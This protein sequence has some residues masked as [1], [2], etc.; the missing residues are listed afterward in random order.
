MSSVAI[1]P[2]RSLSKG[3]KDKNLQTVGGI[4]LVG[5]CIKTAKEANVDR[6]VVSTDGIKLAEEARCWN[7]EIVK[8]P[9][10]LA[11]DESSS[12]AALVHVLETVPELQKYRVLCFLQATSTFCSSESV[13][14]CISAV[15]DGYDCAFTVVPTHCTLWKNGENGPV[16]VNLDPY[17]RSRRQDREPQYKETGAV[18]ALNMKKFL[19]MRT[20]FCGALGM[21]EVPEEE[22]W[23]IDNEHDLRMARLA[24]KKRPTLKEGSRIYVDIDETICV[25]PED[26]DYTKATPILSAIQKINEL[27]K[28]HEVIYWTARG[29]TSGIDW[30]ELTEAQLAAWGAEY[31]ELRMGKPAYDLLFDDKTV[32]SVEEL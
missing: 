13:R 10:S 32:A 25:T 6:V 30:R 19:E 3:I 1:I 24:A 20:R 21:I 28:Y 2:V 7:A 27:A 18:Y 4:S 23:E 17:R 11:T 14:R 29:A 26:R 22:A 12:E 16:G 9:P 8:R 5:R 31:K 15:E